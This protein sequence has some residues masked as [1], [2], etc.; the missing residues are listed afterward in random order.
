MLNM[1][2]LKFEKSCT[3]LKEQL[4]IQE[5]IKQLLLDIKNIMKKFCI[6]LPVYKETLDC[7]EEI[8][9]KR[10]HSVIGEKGYDVYSLARIGK[11]GKG[12]IEFI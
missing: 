6:V 11:L 12:I 10:L 2:I 5:N 9:L 1:P 7:V 8:S 4:E 3:Y